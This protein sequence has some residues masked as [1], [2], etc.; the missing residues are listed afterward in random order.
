V[1]VPFGIL[2][3]IGIVATLPETAKRRLQ[4]DMF[5][6][7]AL[8]LGIGAL[9]L[10]LDRGEL[11]DWFSSTEIQ[12][13]GLIAA[14]GLFLFVVHTATGKNTFISRGLFKDRNFVIGSTFIFMIGVVLFATLALMPPLLQGLMGYP[15]LAAGLVTAPRGV[16]TWVSMV[17]VGRLTGRVD[18][19]LLIAIG[20]GLGAI[21]LWQMGG[22]SPQIDSSPI[23]WSGVI[24]G[25]GTGLAYVSLTVSAFVTLPQM[26]RNEGTA[27]FNLMRNIGSSVGISLI[28]AYVTR[29]QTRA[30]ANLTEAL[31]PYNAL[32]THPQV[33]SQLDSANGLIALNQQVVQQSSWISYLNAF[34][35]MMVLTLVVIPLIFFAR[36]AKAT[37]GSKSMIAE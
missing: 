31:T 23:N 2:A 18:A 13:E 28:Q 19:R 3:A 12:L 22:F 1:N 4:F 25:F 14:V 29:G 21:S 37:A 26:Y 9:Q 35:L 24:Q 7:A 5:G 6:F 33:Y 30:H 11:K 8:S 34:H 27:F 15:V 10:M 36:G 17:V 20:F 32:A 16:G